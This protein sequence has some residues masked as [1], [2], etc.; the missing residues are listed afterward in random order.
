MSFILGSNV[1]LYGFE[2]GVWK[3]FVCGRDCSYSLDT[4]EIEISQPGTGA[5]YTFKP[6]KHTAVFNLSGLVVLDEEGTLS[7]P[8]IRAYQ[9]G[10]L[11]ILL[12]YEREDENANVY[13]EE[14]TGYI[15]SSTDSGPFQDLASF[16][17]T[18]KATG[19]VVLSFV[20]TNTGGGTMTRFEYTGI[21]GETSFS[22]ASL[23]GKDKLV[24]TKDGIALSRIIFT[25]TPLNKEVKYTS[26][27]G[28]FEFPMSIEPGEEV[29]IN[30]QSI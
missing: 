10:R 2:D 11:P 15:I 7:L 1:I 17:V 29:V 13:T 12:R 19:I 20:K 30:Y 6:V 18:I 24:V 26:I 3:P 4:E 8:N 16:D 5:Y 9:M 21:A 23:I 14:A 25:G 28:T 27:T 22:S